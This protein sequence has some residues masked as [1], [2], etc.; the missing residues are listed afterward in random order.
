[1]NCPTCGNRLRVANTTGDRDGTGEP[2]VVRYRVCE[3]PECH[4]RVSTLEIPV[5]FEGLKARVGIGE[6]N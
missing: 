2:Y 6:M 1:M 3:N 5:N 4:R